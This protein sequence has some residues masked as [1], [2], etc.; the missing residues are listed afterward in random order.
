MTGTRVFGG[1]EGG[2][3]HSTLML[4][5]EHSKVLAEVHGPGTNFFQLGMDETCKR[6]ADMVKE[7][8]PKAGFEQ[9]TP[10]V[11]LGLSLSGCEV[12]AK[13]RELGEKLQELYP[14]LTLEL[15]AVCSDTVGSLRTAS[16]SGGVVL[17]AGT[18]SNSLLVNPDGSTH[19][20]GGWGHMLGDEGGAW[21]ISRLAIKVWFDQEDNM[22][23]APYDTTR[24]VAAITD[25]FEIEDRFG[26]LTHCYD[27]FTKPHFAGLCKR[28][29]EEAS[30]GDLLAKWVFSEAGRALAKHIV[31]LSPNMADQVL[32]SL[33]V[34][35][36]GSVWKSWD[37]LKSGFVQ[38]LGQSSKIKEIC[39]HQLKVPMATGACYLAAQNNI[40]RN[41]GDNT[42]VFFKHQFSS[43]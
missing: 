8:L 18:G 16:E 11:S 5:D 6:I 35:C 28:L 23:K 3:T 14:K 31:A 29:A 12:E 26:L 33:S 38:E 22:V 13:N 10:L 19:R 37:F 41:Y 42:T 9:D 43:S 36:I 34:V 1:V 30:N 4:F 7:A 17:I 32:Q 27:K 21:W 39:L 20:C 40:E 25:Y 2:A 15:P 24:V